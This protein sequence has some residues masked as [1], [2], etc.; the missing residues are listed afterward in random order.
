MQSPLSAHNITSSRVC[1][2]EATHLLNTTVAFEDASL[3]LLIGPRRSGKNLLLRTLG[4]M[5]R[6]DRG[7]VSVL[8]RS[9]KE[10][11]DHERMEIRS[12]HFGFVFE[13]PFL[14][15]SFSVVENVAMPFFKLTGASPDVARERT[16][17]ALALTGLTECS[18]MVAEELPMHI[19]LRVALARAV[20]HRPM[21]LF[22]ENIDTLLRNDELITF[23]ELLAHI[24]R[25]M[26]CCILA[27]ATNRDLASFSN[28][29]LEFSGGEITRDWSPGGLLS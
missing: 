7:E 11:G 12:R 6:P 13:S 23:M 1:G 10:W 16:A 26:G 18:E 17:E 24:R 19:Q 8:G 3:N 21:A 2:A 29:A 25:T 20:V 27:T 14:L 15:P 5:D 4:L 22:L 28:R 9:T